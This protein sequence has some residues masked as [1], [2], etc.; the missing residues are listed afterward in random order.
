MPGEGESVKELEAAVG[1]AFG[2]T[3]LLM[4]NAGIQPG[5]QILGPLDGWGE[6]FPPTCGV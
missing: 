4:N 3:E 5:S 6:S 2:G 1:K